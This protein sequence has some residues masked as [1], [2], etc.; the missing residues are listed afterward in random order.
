M[1]KYIYCLLLF[2]IQ[3]STF[4]QTWTGALSTSWDVSGNWNPNVVPTTGSNVTIPAALSNYPVLQTDVTI[5]GITMVPGSSIDFNGKKLSITTNIGVYNNISGAI[6][7]NT[8]AGT[9]IVLEINTGTGGYNTTFNSNTVTD[10]ITFDLS[11]SNSFFEGT[12]GTKNIYT[13]HTT[14]NINGSMD[15]QYA[16][17]LKSENNG[18][19]TFNRTVAGNTNIF[20]AGGLV[21]GNFSYTNLTSGSLS[22]GNSANRTAIGG[23][24][25][26]T[27][28]NLNTSAYPLNR[29]I[30]QTPGGVI[31]VQNTLGFTVS[32]DTLLVSS[33]SLTG[34]RGANYAVFSN[35]KISG[36]LTLID[37]LTYTGGYNT[38]VSR[39]D[40]GGTATF[41]INGTNSFLEANETNSQNTFGGNVSYSATGIATLNIGNQEK[42]T[43]GGNVNISRSGAGL[44]VIFGKGSSIAGNFS[45][46][47]T[48]SGSATLG[49]SGSK[50]SIS[51]TVNININNTATSFFSLS[52]FV[53]LTPGGSI[54][55]Q[56]TLGFS[57]SND[58]LLVTSFSLTGYRGANYASLSNNKISG[59]L[60]I[61]D[62]SSYT[63]GFDTRILRN[64]I[65][66]NSNFTIYGS[67]AFFESNETNGQNTFGGNV[68]YTANGSGPLNIG[69]QE[70]STYGGNVS[71]S[72]TA[73]GSSFIFGKGA[74]IAG[75]FSFNNSTSGLS[76]LG[77]TNHRT[78]IAGTVNITIANVALSQFG[79]YRF[80]NQT[81]GGTVSISNTQAFDVFN[82]T[83]LVN[84]LSVLNYG[85]NGYAQFYNN[86]ISGDL[87]LTSDASYG[88]GYNTGIANNEIGGDVIFTNTGSNEMND[89]IGTNV[90]NKYFG[91][92]TYHKIGGNINVATNS[93]NEYGKGITFNSTGGITINRAKFMSAADGIL[94]QLGTQAIVISNIKLEKI[95]AGKLTLNS[96]LTV[97][98]TIAF[99]SGYIVAS[100]TKELI[101]PDNIGYTGASDASYVVGQVI[102]RGD[103]AFSFPVGGG[104]KLA[105]IGISA[106]SNVSDEFRVLYFDQPVGNSIQ[107]EISIDHISTNE[108]WL[109][110]RA[111][112]T[113]NVL[114]SLG[115]ETARSGIV[116]S[117][118]DLRIVAYEVDTW[119]NKGNGGTTGTNLSGEIVSA[120]A[121]SSFG[122]FTLASANANNSFLPIFESI[123]T[124]LWNVGS[125]WITPSNPVVPTS[126]KI[127]KIN[128]TH[129][130]SIS[131]TGN[132]IKTVQMNGGTINLN[133]GTLE[134][135]NQ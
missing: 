37:D 73:A 4:A 82:D 80:V 102:K 70:R 57:V 92:V 124:G 29:I 30:N 23:K 84:S 16:Q 90:G 8:L 129:T 130:V 111:V 51:G 38:K 88:G 54:S 81:A 47:N 131:N 18:N 116:D 67:N 103:D 107:K 33:F 56:N 11:N 114:V 113:S 48:T 72:R 112:G 24:I 75:T 44:T 66:G 76:S 3:L 119:I 126:K 26:I 6:L 122:L 25:D 1:K 49:Q 5:N 98:T 9:D 71:I 109:L 127:A 94:E 63:G 110:V 39:N 43:Y 85:G 52:R 125:T 2:T 100:M 86:K 36:N 60:T 69:N 121:I 77:Q 53:N 132:N 40:I 83:L 7:N 46:T 78:A 89:A 135:K 27:V 12:S 41:V 68:S 105:K 133:G 93:E 42:S 97:G 58:T 21:T 64:E 95:G 22:I 55:V 91:N 35:N 62:H 61:T 34:Y 134:I 17:N 117:P 123:N 19:L 14:Y 59:D 96:P 65:G 115:W 101:F 45:Y 118:A 106:P 108:T 87:F 10:N 20:N 31:S 104:G 128:S 120:A 15:F 13:G 50:T 28:N 79:L 99:T 74:N 32:S